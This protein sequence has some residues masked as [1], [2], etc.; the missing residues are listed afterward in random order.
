MKN[1]NVGLEEKIYVDLKTLK[2]GLRLTWYEMFK[3]ISENPEEF[4]ELM[5][6]FLR[7][8]DGS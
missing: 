5:Q 1:I 4:S 6:S 8:G 2:K 7:N 3:I